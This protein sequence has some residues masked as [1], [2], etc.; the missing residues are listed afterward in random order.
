MKRFKLITEKCHPQKIIIAGSNYP[1][2]VSEIDKDSIGTIPRKEITLWKDIKSVFSDSNKFCFGDYGIIHPDFRQSR[3]AK[4]QNA[5][6]RYTQ[7]EQWVVARGHKLIDTP[8]EEQFLGL[9]RDFTG[10]S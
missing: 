4:N 7:P 10:S 1:T 5:K 9:A 2:D 3:P 8:G 6:I